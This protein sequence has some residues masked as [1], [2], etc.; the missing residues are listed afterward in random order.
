MISNA[1]FRLPHMN[2]IPCR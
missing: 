1:S 2:T